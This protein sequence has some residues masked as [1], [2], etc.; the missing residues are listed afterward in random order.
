VRHH[1]TAAL[2]LLL[3]GAARAEAGVVIEKNGNVFVGRVDPAEV[4]DEKIVMHDARF[5][6]NDPPLKN[7]MSFERH[8]V[9]WFD[10]DSDEPT[11]A[12][13]KLFPDAPI[14]AR[15]LPLIEILKRPPPTVVVDPGDWIK[16]MPRISA[17]PIEQRSGRD[18]LTIR[19]PTGWSATTS[20]EI[21]MFES[22]RKG[23]D[24]FAP[25]IH[26]FSQETTGTPTEQL[27]WIKAELARTGGT[28]VEATE[29]RVVRGGSDVSLLTTT[30]TG[31]RAIR[32][33]R[34]I[35][36]REHRTYFAVAYSQE[37]DFDGLRPLLEA[38][39]ATVSIDESDPPKTPERTP[40]KA[41]DEKKGK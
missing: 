4:T 36:F 22:D 8:T 12:Y 30:H 26:V 31:G 13:V 19:K 6:R 17:V 5:T 9:R 16:N 11:L 23:T 38:S 37:S 33:L 39:L 18:A 35:F 20:G 27:A 2:A 15:W 34:K 24:G 21:L 32:A 40:A 25:R 28:E 14:Q 1:L 41:P 7:V 10:A 3:L 29:P